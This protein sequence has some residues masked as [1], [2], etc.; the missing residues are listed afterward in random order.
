M[1]THNRIAC[2]FLLLL[3]VHL[4]AGDV[5]ARE[6]AEQNVITFEVGLVRISTL[7]EGQQSGNVNV[8]KGATP[9]MLRTH[10]PEGNYPTAI[11]A[12]LVRTEDKNI[13]V[14]A[15]LG[16][17]L[18]DNL[19]SLGI[20][21]QQID[22]ILLTHMHGDHIGGLL[23]DEQTVFPDAELYL[24]QAEHDYW[25]SDQAM[26]QAG[27]DRRNGFLQARKV[28]A[29]YGERLH[30]F[31]PHEAGNGRSELMPGIQGIAAYGHT[32]GHTAYLIES[33][34]ESLLIW[35]D[36]THATAIQMPC[37]DVAVIYDINPV[38]AVE[39]RKKILEY[40][41]GNNLSIAG[42]HIAFPAVGEVIRTENKAGSYTFA[43]FCL[44]LGI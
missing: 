35:G 7:S 6:K 24:A 2:L 13:L 40:A 34:N 43:P 3:L 4:P 19:Q 31:T 25:M 16:R 30:L 26:Q 23:R 18:T 28:I 32:P 1:A 15:G 17:L 44:C 39:S 14:D 12:F 5:T 38:Q 21:P 36:L 42:M 10:L 41:V 8:L 11:N 33:D 29:A 27:P 20:T 22:V 9:E 37:P